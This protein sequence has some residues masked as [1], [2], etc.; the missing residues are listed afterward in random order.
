MLAI[1]GHWTAPDYSLKTVLLGIKELHG[2]HTGTKIADLLLSLFEELEIVKVL[3]YSVTDNV[4]NNDIA[5]ESLAHSLLTKY[6]IHYNASSHRLH[7]IGHIINLVVKALLFGT[8]TS[9]IN[10]PED[11]PPINEYIGAIRKLHHI[12]HHIRMTPQHRDLYYSEQAASLQIS[13]EFMVV[14]N[15]VTRWNSTY[16]MIKSALQLQQR[17]DGY[18]RLVGKELDSH[19]LSDLDWQDLS[20]LS[21]M[22]APFEKVV[23]ITQV[24]NQGQGSIVSVLLSMDMLLSRLESIKSK[25]T[26]TSSE[27]YSTVDSAWSKLNKYYTLTDRSTIYVISIILHSCMKMKYFQQ[28]WSD[29]PTWIIDARQQMETYYAEYG[30][31]VPVISVEP[32]SQSEMD[33]WYFGPMNPSETELD[34]YLA[35]PVITLRG[36]E[37]LETFN[38]VHW[39]QGNEG[40]YLILSQIAYNIFAVSA[41]SAEVERVFSRYVSHEVMY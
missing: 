39:W 25:S 1:V 4:G 41:M 9:A 40:S 20:E 11:E 7:C 32:R 2:S 36:E 31:A 10:G 3:R 26:V 6:N 29:H 18:V 24:N 23:C 27:F 19:S 22:L 21:I 16:Y 33:D 30:R 8:N 14:A 15:N 28:H 13:P 17:I 5:L 12:V 35:T 38:I 37:T 34:E